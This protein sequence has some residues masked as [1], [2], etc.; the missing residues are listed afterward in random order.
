LKKIKKIDERTKNA[1][2]CKNR[3]SK[4]K[5][6]ENTQTL[7]KMFFKKSIKTDQNNYIDNLAKMA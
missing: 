3:T 6:L 2:L 7:A 5:A 4:A 1:N